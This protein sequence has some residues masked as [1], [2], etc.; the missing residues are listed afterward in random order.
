MLKFLKPAILKTYR[1]LKD[2]SI[3]VTFETNELAPEEIVKL[4]SL[5]NTYGVLY[6]KQES[7]LTEQELKDLDSLE[8][9]YNGI[10]KSK[11]LKNV[12]Y[13]LW[14]KDKSGMTNEQYYAKTMDNLIEHFKKKLD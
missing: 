13:R 10:S 5:H 8:M 3:N 11:R 1:P 4:H 12:L 9:E 2:G 14:E 7:Q 6:F